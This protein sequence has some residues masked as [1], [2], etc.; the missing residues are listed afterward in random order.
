MLLHTPSPSA[1]ETDREYGL[2]RQ[3]ILLY[4]SIETKA[5]A[6]EVKHAK[7]DEDYNSKLKE[8]VKQCIDKQYYQGVKTK[9]RNVVCYGLAC[10][11]KGCKIQEVELD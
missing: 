8:A 10:Y 11:K 4:N 3:D 2:G 7:E 1:F 6:I 5:I 9:F